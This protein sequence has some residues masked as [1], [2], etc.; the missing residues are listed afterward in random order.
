VTVALGG[1]LLALAGLADDAAGAERLRAAFASGAAAE[2]FDRMVAALGGPRSGSTPCSGSARR[3]RPVTR[4]RWCMPP[5]RGG[6]AR[7]QAC[8]AAYR[9]APDA[10][11][12]LPLIVERVG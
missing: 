8:R 4:W 11:E 5:T 3:W 10:P 2:R 6:R 7:G 9:I 12:P 1:E